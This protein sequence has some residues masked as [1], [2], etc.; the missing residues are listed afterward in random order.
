[1]LDSAVC[2]VIPALLASICQQIWG[3]Q[4]FTCNLVLLGFHLNL[5]LFK[6]ISFHKLVDYGNDA[7]ETLGG[8]RDLELLK[9]SHFARV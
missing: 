3:M 1:M 7:G 9:V 4:N 2:V 6:L 8:V 5:K